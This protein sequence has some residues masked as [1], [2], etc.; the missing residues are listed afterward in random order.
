MR[1]FGYD[2][3]AALSAPDR[4]AEIKREYDLAGAERSNLRYGYVCRA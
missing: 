3:H 4:F 2:Q 1:I